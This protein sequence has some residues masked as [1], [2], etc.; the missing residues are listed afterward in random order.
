MSY[1]ELDGYGGVEYREELPG[2]ECTTTLGVASRFWERSRIYGPDGLVWR[3]VPAAPADVVL[4]VL[5]W[6]L[7]VVYNPVR[8]LSLRYERTGEYQLPQLKQRIRECVEQDDDILTQFME[9]DEI[10]AA[11]DKATDFEA[12]AALV[13]RMGED[14]DAAE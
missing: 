7:A 12:V 13:K 10:K 2:T 4:P 5:P 3:P 14:Q 6:L 9:A 1:I 11:L 8:T